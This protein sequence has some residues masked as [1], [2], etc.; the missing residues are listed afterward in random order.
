MLY[1]SVMMVFV[2]ASHIVILKHVFWSNVK[3]A[4]AIVI[5]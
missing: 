4:N 2:N 3:Y 1:G 5:N